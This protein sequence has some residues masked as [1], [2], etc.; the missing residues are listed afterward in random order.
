MANFA[1]D[2]ESYGTGAGIPSGYTGRWNY[3][4]G[5]WDRVTDTDVA[6]R[7]V[8]TSINRTAVTRND[9][10][11]DGDRANCDILFRMKST[12]GTGSV[13]RSG[14]VARASGSAG[15]ETGYTCAINDT[16]LRIGKYSGGSSSQ[17]GIT[18]GK[19][20]GTGYYWVRF[21]VNGTSSP[22]SQKARV[23]TGLESDEPTGSWDLDL[24][25]STSPIT[26]NGWCGLFNFADG[27]KHWRDLAIATNGDTATMS[28]PPAGDGVGSS[29]GAAT[30]AATGA[31]TAAAAAS[32]SGA[33]TVTATGSS[34]AAT[35]GAITATSTASAVG[36]G[37]TP[38]YRPISDI[39]ANGWTPS[40]GTD[41]FAMIDDVSLDRGDYIISPNLTDPSTVG[42]ATMP[43]GSYT[44]SVD[45]DRTDVNG[46]LRL[47][48]LDS[49]GTV[50]GTSSWQAAPASAATLPFTVTTTGTTE[51]LRFEV[52]P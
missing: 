30:V 3:A 42:W 8:E 36:E 35:V 47:V 50:L 20:L 44:F 51:Q 24:S 19:S 23:W 46:Q 45:F 14:A 9:V 18:T 12:V 26:A 43:A 29:A 15:S 32:S 34:V 21:R 25:D 17:V 40:T 27:T 4:A 31:S 41:L 10:D 49:G 16:D 1:D 39:S 6:V 37:G 38:T 13:L 48:A 28:S 7:N 5:E 52:Q 22:V 2:F 33:A 11:A